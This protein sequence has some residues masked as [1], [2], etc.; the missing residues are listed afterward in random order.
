MKQRRRQ[1]CLVGSGQFMYTFNDIRTR[2]RKPE[3]ATEFSRS[4]AVDIAMCF[5]YPQETIDKIENARTR[6]EITAILE[7][8][9]ISSIIRDFKE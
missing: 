9:R 2:K 5:H 3:K 4:N 1:L 8:A 6:D 7:K